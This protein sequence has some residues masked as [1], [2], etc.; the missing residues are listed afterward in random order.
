[1][2][3]RLSFVSRWN[4]FGVLLDGI[5]EGKGEL[6]VERLAKVKEATQRVNLERDKI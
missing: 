6:F 4:H 2:T 1:M 5:F 3:K